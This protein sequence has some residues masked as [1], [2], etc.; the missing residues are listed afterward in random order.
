[1]LKDVLFVDIR[2]VCCCLHIAKV[3]RPWELQLSPYVHW[4]HNLLAHLTQQGKPQHLKKGRGKAF[5]RIGGSLT[6]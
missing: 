5:T 4:S 6:R 3:F 1:M 2:L